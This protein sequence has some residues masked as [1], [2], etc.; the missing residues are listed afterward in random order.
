M[1]A[2]TPAWQPQP[3][4]FEAL[5]QK[6]ASELEQD[7]DAVLS[8]MSRIEGV[9]VGGLAIAALALC[10][11]N[12]VVRY[13]HPAWTLEMVDELQVYVIVWAVFLALGAVTIAD[14]HVKADLFVSFFSPRLRRA[15]ELFVD[16]LGLAFALLLLWYGSVAA[17]QSWSYGD[18][19]TTSLRFPLWIYVAALPAGGL[20]LAIG[21]VTRLARLLR[22][23]A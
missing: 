11:Y 9:I 18:L 12:V 13:F 20:T 23:E 3:A 7:G 6:A 16:L 10:T 8:L 17:Y 21:Y 4:V 15:L 1:E 19:S 5:Q 14:R 22:S 2:N